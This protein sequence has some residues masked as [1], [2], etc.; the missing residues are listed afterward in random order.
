[1]AKPCAGREYKMPSDAH[2]PRSSCW[3]FVLVTEKGAYRCTS[4]QICLDLGCLH[5]CVH[6][7]TRAKRHRFE[8]DLCDLCNQGNRAVDADAHT[9]TELLDVAQRSPPDVARAGGVRLVARQRDGLWPDHR[10]R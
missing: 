6:R 7:V 9:L 4:D 1:M 2:S 5:R 8:R 10:K 3:S